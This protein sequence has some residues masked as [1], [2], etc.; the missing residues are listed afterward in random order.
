VRENV[1]T[2]PHRA[3][4]GCLLHIL[5]GSYHLLRCTALLEMVSA[6]P[7]PCRRG[8]AKILTPINRNNSKYGVLLLTLRY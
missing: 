8:D 2:H 4:I 1:H 5:V 3:E 7:A 6:A